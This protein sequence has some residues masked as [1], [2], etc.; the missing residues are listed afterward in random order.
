MPSLASKDLTKYLVYYF[1]GTAIFYSFSIVLASNRIQQ[2]IGGISYPVFLLHEPLIGR[3]ISKILSMLSLNATIF[4]LCWLIMVFVITWLTIKIF[5]ML[6]L[7]KFLWR[8][9]ISEK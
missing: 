2:W 6:K 1:I 3:L 4:T 5:Q 8:Y 9:Y 7:D